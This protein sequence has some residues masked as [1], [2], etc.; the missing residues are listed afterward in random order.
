MQLS[1]NQSHEPPIKIK[2]KTNRSDIIHAAASKLAESHGFT[3]GP[4]ARDIAD[5]EIVCRVVFEYCVKALFEGRR[6]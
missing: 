2:K 6:S 5:A 3:H 1:L 4:R